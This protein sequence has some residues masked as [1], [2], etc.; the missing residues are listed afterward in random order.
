M[1]LFKEEKKYRLT[2]KHITLKTGLI[3]YQIKA[4]QDF[5][6]VC[7]GQLGGYVQS[8]A[9]LSHNDECWIY[10]QARVY[11]NAKVEKKA[12]IFNQVCVSGNVLITDNVC[13]YDDVKVQD[14]AHLYDYCIICDQVNI[15]SHATLNCHAQ[16]TKNAR[17]HD[18]H[19]FYTGY[20]DSQHRHLNH[21]PITIFYSLKHEV[22]VVY[23]NTTYN[24]QGFINH[25][26]KELGYIAY[27]EAFRP[28][29]VNARRTMYF[30]DII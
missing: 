12:K 16:I 24:L 21:K 19:D 2:R 23:D 14:D 29:L 4:L 27:A 11:E 1:N 18:N 25:I 15:F 17:I 13:L 9:N 5:G 6:D 22:R 30:K 26:R 3:L 7:K 10:D 8:E 20:L 28:Q